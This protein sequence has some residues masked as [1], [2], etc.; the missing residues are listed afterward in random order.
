[1]KILSIGSDKKIFE[2][3]SGV[4]KRLEKYAGLCE[5]MSVVVLTRQKFPDIDRGNLRVYATGSSSRLGYFF[6]AMRLIK[7]I[8]KE[9]KF[10]LVTTQDPFEMGLLGWLTKKR[11]GLPWQVQ[12]HGDIL[13]PYFRRE[14]LINR[15]RVMLAKF[16]LPKADGIRVVS[17]RIKKSL[18]S[19]AVVLPIFVDVQKLKSAEVKTDLKQK[20]PQFDF[21]ILMAS[22]L[23]K[24]KNIALAVSALS[25][26]SPSHP[27]VGLVIVGEG[28]E[29][30]NLESLV[31][32]HK[33]ENNIVFEPWSNEL[34][35]YYKTADAFLLTSDYEGWGMTVVEAAACAC[36][37][38]MT[39]VGCAGE[40]IKNEENGLVVLVGDKQATV[41]AIEKLISDESLRKRLGLAAQKSAESLPDEAEYL[42]AYKRSWEDSIA[43]SLE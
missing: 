17:E 5:K 40:F 43:R 25:Q 42:E 31:K 2:P 30:E 4:A 29:K 28:K 19:N 13:S 7:Q 39:D 6:D 10:D 18:I 3:E 35:S 16:L 41:K 36:P 32:S 24:E 33:L 9:E 22:R 12:I 23:G 15:L 34:A 8:L 21:I 20:Y 1:M 37:I 14:S 26:I 11:Y 38:I 27:R